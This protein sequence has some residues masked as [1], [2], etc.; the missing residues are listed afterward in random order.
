M[1]QPFSDILCVS[2]LLVGCV[3]DVRTPVIRGRL[4]EHLC[5]PSS[6]RG[7]AQVVSGYWIQAEGT[8]GK[9]RTEAKRRGSLGIALVP[10]VVGAFGHSL[11]LATKAKP[12]TRRGDRALPANAPG[13]LQD[14]V[15]S[16]RAQGR[17]GGDIPGCRVSLLCYIATVGPAYDSTAPVPAGREPISTSGPGADPSCDRGRRDRFWRLV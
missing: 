6:S 10:P 1:S 7:Q 13:C 11:G 17:T 12:T 9:A 4:L 16:C 3:F 14:C 5:L 15:T 8:D 2:N